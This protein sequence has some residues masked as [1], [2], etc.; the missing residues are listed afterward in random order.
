MPELPDL[1]VIKLNLEKK[2][3]GLEVESLKLWK[4]IV[5]KPSPEIV[6]EALKGDRIS[7]VARRGK[8]ILLHLES[9]ATLLIHLMLEG[10]LD[11]KPSGSS[12]EKGTCAVLSFK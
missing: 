11:L 12:L 8:Y 3:R 6:E 7:S 4:K 10:E 5:G 1:E 2:I 9:G